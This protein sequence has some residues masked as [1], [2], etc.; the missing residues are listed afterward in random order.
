MRAIVTI[1]VITIIIVLG[2]ILFGRSPKSGTG[3]PKLIVK[4]LADYSTTGATVKLTIDGLING[5]DEHRQIR[6]TVG[7]DQRT[8]DIIQGYQGHIIKT[9]S[10]S[11]NQSGY[12]IFLRSLNLAGFTRIRKTK[13]I[14]E[15]G[16]CSLGQRFIYELDGTGSAKTDL[17]LWSTSCGGNG[18]EGGQTPLI[19]QLF[20]NQVTGYDDIVGAVNI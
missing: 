17:R 10:F 5:D 9:K 4:S 11:N 3:K 20:K 19:Q 8:I 7:R 1:V 13:I 15:R 12:D 2:V 14:D 16:I 18:T 6:V